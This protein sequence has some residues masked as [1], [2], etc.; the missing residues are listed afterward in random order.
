M[1]VHHQQ[2]GR[3]K[4][5]QRHDQDEHIRELLRQHPP[6]GGG[7]FLSRDFVDDTALTPDDAFAGARDI[8][9]E[10]VSD[11]PDVRPLVGAAE[12]ASGP[13]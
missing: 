11:H 8:V 3:E 9:A 12:D 10:T 1:P 13:V 2:Q 6:A 4:H 5:R 7:T